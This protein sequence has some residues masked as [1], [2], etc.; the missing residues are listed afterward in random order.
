VILEVNL[1][2]DKARATLE[3]IESYAVDKMSVHNTRLNMGKWIVFHDVLGDS[4]LTDWM[5]QR[6]IKKMIEA[7]EC[8]HKEVR[9]LRQRL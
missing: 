2:I 4:F 3:E 8:A 6:R 7:V 9:D 5:V 1:F